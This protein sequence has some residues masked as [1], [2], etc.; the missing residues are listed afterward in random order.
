MSVCALRWRMCSRDD[1][2]TDMSS[3]HSNG[4]GRP[5]FVKLVRDRIGDL[6][7]ESTVTYAPIDVEDHELLLQRKLREEAIEFADDPCVEELADVWQAMVDVV[8]VMGWSLDEVNRVRVAKLNERG[9]FLE[10]TGMYVRTAA[11]G[12]RS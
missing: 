8:H 12:R 6:L 10:G 11:K 2:A 4:V 9:G 7:P 3:E 1:F 5:R